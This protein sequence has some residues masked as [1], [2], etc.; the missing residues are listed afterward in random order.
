MRSVGL[1]V[2]MVVLLLG[3]CSADQAQCSAPCAE[4]DDARAVMRWV[5]D[6]SADGETIRVRYHP[7]AR[8]FGCAV[9]EGQL[10]DSGPYPIV[11]DT[12]AAGAVFLND[13]HVRENKLPVF[14]LPVGDHPATLCRLQR[15]RLG[16]MELQRPTCWYIQLE[17]GRPNSQGTPPAP[18]Q[19]LLQNGAANRTPAASDRSVIIGLP[20]LRELSYVLLDD[21]RQEA[22]MSLRAPFEPTRPE[23]WSRYPLTVLD[24]AHGYPSLFAHLTLAGQS[25]P[26]QLDTGSAGGLAATDRLWRQISG[27]FPGVTLKQDAVLYP[28]IGRLSCQRGIVP[29][30]ELGTQTLRQWEVLVFP[31]DSALFADGQAIIGMGCFRNAI[32]VLDFQRGVLWVRDGGLKAR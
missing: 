22:E 28:Y 1:S 2:V 17:Q 19:S 7:L 10:E 5:I 12:G 8:E 16:A 31:D 24:D 3:G 13:I 25:L 27:E 29:R 23:N 11:L 18:A 14:Q 4:R 9:V 20:A 6:P 26:V 15:V 21:V 30:L 32:A